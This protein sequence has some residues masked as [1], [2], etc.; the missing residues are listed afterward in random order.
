MNG[1]PACSALVT[2][3]MLFGCYSA[4]THILRVDR[5][6]EFDA[7]LTKGNFSQVKPEATALLK[8]AKKVAIKPPSHCSDESAR[9][10]Q[11]GRTGRRDLVEQ[12]G[13]IM[14]SIERQLFKLGFDV[15]SW[16]QLKARGAEATKG[17]DLVL[18]VNELSTKD[19]GGADGVKV[20]ATFETEEAGK[21]QPL[22]LPADSPAIARCS[23][24]VDGL[25]Q[26]NLHA[27]PTATINTKLV[28]PTDG[29]VIWFFQH[30]E[31]E[32]PAAS[33]ANSSEALKY[34][35]TAA[36]K[37]LTRGGRA[38]LGLGMGLVGVV[39]LASSVGDLEAEEGCDEDEDC[40]DGDPPAG[41]VLGT[42]AG[43]GLTGGGL[44][45]LLT[46]LG[47][48]QKDAVSSADAVLCN[49]DWR[50]NPDAAKVPDAPKAAPMVSG[51]STESKSRID[52][53]NLAEVARRRVRERVIDVMVKTISDIRN[54]AHR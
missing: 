35:N 29:A 1:I 53:G 44:V 48:D 7:S 20:D 34:K 12:C 32:K 21:R 51:L 42:A 50:V 15:V 13:V 10:D 49:S 27:V 14:S 23:K 38:L 31:V 37:S 36:D 28:R 33:S 46:A 52:E 24:V 41:A 3:L 39:L 26:S 54:G 9:A 16:Q 6:G 4:P 8:A 30:T 47:G 17:V 19:Y 43:I 45:L 40:G 5:T 2:M 22:Q 11:Q 25:K 18:E